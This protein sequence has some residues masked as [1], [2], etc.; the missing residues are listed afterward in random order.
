MAN[1]NSIEIEGVVV[2]ALP[3]ATFLVKVNI[4][5]GKEHIV[6]AMLS[7]KMKTRW[8]R[9]LPGDKVR[10]VVVPPD[11]TQGRITYRFR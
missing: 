2:E 4:G 5:D 11:L 1:S 9:V 8:I 3:N 7:G 10:L 6:R